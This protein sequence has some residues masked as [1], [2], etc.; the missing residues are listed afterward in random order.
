MP[1]VDELAGYRV[2]RTAGHGDRS[3]L[4]LGFHDGATVVLKV[5]DRDDPSALAEIEALHRAAGEH[6]VE[7]C[8][9]AA[10]ENETVLVLERLTKGSLADLLEQRGHLDAGEAVTILAPIA[11][12]IERLHHAG[13]AHGR[14]SLGAICFRDDGAPTLV[15]F[16]GARTFAPNSPD[17]VLETVLEVLADREAVRAI[18]ALVL[19]RVGGAAATAAQRLAGE[20]AGIAPGDL[21]PRLFGLAAPTAVRFGDDADEV[22]TTRLGDLHAAEAPDEVSGVTLPPWLVPLVPEWLI[23]HVSG[24]VDRLAAVWTGWS[25]RRKRLTLGGF[26]AGLTVVVAV[27]ATP[28]PAEPVVVEPAA[29][30]VGAIAVEAPQLPDDPVE[31]ATVLLDERQRC[32]RDLSLLCLDGVA[33]AGSAAFAE[34]AALIRDLQA[35]GEYPAQRILA[36]SPVLIE[37]LGDAALLDL[38]PGSVP[39]SVLLLKTVDGWRIRQYLEGSTEAPDVSAEPVPGG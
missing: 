24:P 16:G 3:R 5:T 8:D 2:L 37:R 23:E 30:E 31:A 7:L 22:A 1:L 28:M 4:V 36:G 10:D 21:A 35:G 26:A 27:A 39:A 6:V 15:G 18:C 20:V 34:D 25:I 17:V 19:G 11:A 29:D 9:V 38:A 14:L 12:A 33:Q 32:I 13:V